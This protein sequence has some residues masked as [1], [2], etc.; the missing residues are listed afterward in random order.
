MYVY[1][2]WARMLV[3]IIP[4]NAIFTQDYN[5]SF[6]YGTIRNFYTKTLNAFVKGKLDPW[7][8]GGCS[9]PFLWHS[10]VW[11]PNG[12][13]TNFSLSAGHETRL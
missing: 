5:N 2:R 6:N 11:S 10:A 7:S 8:P 13:I 4:H 12:A 3:P 1:A 9:K